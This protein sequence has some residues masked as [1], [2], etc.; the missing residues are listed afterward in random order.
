MFGMMFNLPFTK[1]YIRNKP[2]YR[3]ENTTFY[4]TL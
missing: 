4:N 1:I 2:N 3:K